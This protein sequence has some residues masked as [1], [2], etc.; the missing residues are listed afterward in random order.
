MCG[1][2]TPHHTALG[3]MQHGNVAKVFHAGL[4][5]AL[6]RVDGGSLKLVFPLPEF[7]TVSH[8][9]SEATFAKL[10]DTA[11]AVQEEKRSRVR[12]WLDARARARVCV[13]VCVCVCGGSRSD[14]TTYV[15]TVAGCKIVGTCQLAQGRTGGTTRWH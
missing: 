1:P 2:C 12:A 5:E 15:W 11:L 8:L 7:D 4:F 13:C 3:G 14:L 10:A 6:I 9:V